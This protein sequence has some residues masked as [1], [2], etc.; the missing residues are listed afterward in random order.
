MDLTH[1]IRQFRT[2]RILIV[3]FIRQC[4]QSS[5]VELA[6]LL[7]KSMEGFASMYPNWT[8]PYFF[9]SIR[10]EIGWN[11]DD[12]LFTHGIP[13]HFRSSVGTRSS[14]REQCAAPYPPR[15]FVL[16]AALTH[17]LTLGAHA[18]CRERR[19]VA[20]NSPAMSCYQQT[21]PFHQTIAPFFKG[22]PGK[23]CLRLETNFQNFSQCRT[24]III[25]RSETKRTTFWIECALRRPQRISL[26]WRFLTD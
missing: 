25:V 2:T 1:L 13:I 9:R 4:F 17:A 10:F 3:P 24:R 16:C 7:V 26:C 18:F 12:T 22:P 20:V 5:K 14:F 21:V 8:P 15:V 11:C 23:S 6:Y 19:D